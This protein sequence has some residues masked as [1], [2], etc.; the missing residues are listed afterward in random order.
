MHTNT[1]RYHEKGKTRPTETK[2]PP[3]LSTT[4]PPRAVLLTVNTA[5]ACSHLLEAT[6]ARHSDS[7]TLN[8]H[9]GQCRFLKT[10]DRFG[11]VRGQTGPQRQEKDVAFLVIHFP[12][13]PFSDTQ[14]PV[15]MPVSP[16]VKRHLGNKRRAHTAESSSRRVCVCGQPHQV[17][18]KVCFHSSETPG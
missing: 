16:N 13:M 4:D 12:F 1:E 18:S 14:L 6:Q 9:M 7:F 2:P 3:L 15:Y 17:K 5:A 11:R 10:S 8:P